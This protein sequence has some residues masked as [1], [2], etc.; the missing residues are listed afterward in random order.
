MRDIKLSV[1]SD[2]QDVRNMF[3]ALAADNKDRF[4]RFSIN[5]VGRKAFTHTIRT[6]SKNLSMPQYALRGGGRSKAKSLIRPSLAYDSNLT[7]AIKAKAKYLFI[8]EVYFKPRWSRAM[9]GVSAMYYGKRRTFK[10]SF[11]GRGKNSGKLIA[12]K[13]EGRSR[14]PIRPIFAFNPAVEM[15]KEEN[16]SHIDD[17]YIPQIPSVY[18]KKLDGF[19]SKR[20][21]TMKMRK[22]F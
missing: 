19:M 6:M 22:V 10:G 14:Y 17:I 7:F 5:Q 3:F 8:S 13:R 16:S 1:T 11:L 9:K 15:I 20:K 4:L 2:I 21:R 18:Y 12:F